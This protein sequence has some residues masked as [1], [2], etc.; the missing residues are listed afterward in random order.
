[1][2]KKVLLLLMACLMATSLVLV[3]CGGTD[4][5]EFADKYIAASGKAWGQGD[6]SDLKKLEDPDIIIHMHNLGFDLEGW[7][8]HEQIILDTREMISGMQHEWKYL[9]GEGNHFAMAYKSH[10]A[11]PGETPD[12]TLDVT[13][14]SLF[15][16]RL[17]KGRVVEV[18]VNGS[19]TME[20]IPSG[21]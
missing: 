16:F 17:D 15:V 5:R 19:T 6:T 8:A 20:P 9:T 10:S 11:M 12:I 1:M 3:S 18:W 7:E 2:N 21:Q 13:N 14:S 4:P